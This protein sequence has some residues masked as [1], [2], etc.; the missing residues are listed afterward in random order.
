MTNPYE[1]ACTK[2]GHKFTI[3]KPDAPKGHLVGTGWPSWRYGPGG[4][5][6]ICQS[7]ADVPQGWTE[8]PD[9]LDRSK[10]IASEPAEET[11]LSREQIIEALRE[12]GYVPGKKEA[13]GALYSRLMAEPEK[14]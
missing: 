5:S 2:C 13:T 14:K 8:S 6:K 1:V 4:Q 3:K 12:R 7:A 11:P 10:P 9:Q